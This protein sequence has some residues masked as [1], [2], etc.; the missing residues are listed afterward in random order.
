M[1]HLSLKSVN[2]VWLKT[3]FFSEE[4]YFRTYWWGIWMAFLPQGEGIW[5]SQSSKVQ[6][7]G[8]LS[9]GWMLK[10]QFDWYLICKRKFTWQILYDKWN[11]HA[12]LI[13]NNIWNIKNV[14]KFSHLHE[15]IQFAIVFASM[16]GALGSTT[17]QVGISISQYTKLLE[18]IQL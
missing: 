11:W 6:M 13:S 12:S 16:H 10:L 15:Q 2:S 18:S 14:T 1:A 4:R 7:P 9:R 17:L 5:K 3:K 8:D